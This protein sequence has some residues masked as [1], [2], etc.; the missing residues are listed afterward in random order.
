MPMR[1]LHIRGVPG[2][3]LPYK[4]AREG[5]APRGQAGALKW[6]TASNNMSRMLPSES[7]SSHMPSVH[8]QPGQPLLAAIRP[9]NVAQPP[10]G[11]RLITAH[12]L[13]HCHDRIIFR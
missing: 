4:R 9:R 7:R 2:S 12:L 8:C 13:F 3:R 6:S 10:L 1:S 11:S 5:V